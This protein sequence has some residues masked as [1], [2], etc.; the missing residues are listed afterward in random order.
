MRTIGERSSAFDR[1]K[2]SS[3]AQMT[4]D[5]GGHNSKDSSGIRMDIDW[6]LTRKSVGTALFTGSTFIVLLPH[7]A[8]EEV[9]R[10]IAPG[11]YNR[12]IRNPHYL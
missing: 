9:A 3:E 6:L 5:G 10:R 4:V 1:G 2:R 11:G 12:R 8:T 7:G